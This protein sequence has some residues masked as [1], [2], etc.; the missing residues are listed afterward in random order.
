M[1]EKYSLSWGAIRVVEPTLD[2]V[3]VHAVALADFYNANRA[4]LTNEQDFDATDVVDQFEEM[5]TTGDRPF[6]LYVGQELV[7]DC[8][9]RHIEGDHAE[10]AV[11]VG[12]RTLQARGLGTWFSTM[13]H[14]LAF[15]SLGMRRVYAAVRP[16]NAGSLR[17]F[18][19]LG[20]E[21][22]RTHRYAEA[23]DDVCVS[24]D[25]ET[26]RRVHGAAVA[27]VQIQTRP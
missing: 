9:L 16:E 14:V 23:A 20:Y 13:V 22:D 25:A 27:V 11:L 7:G 4:L 24:I 17:M 19:K 18:E 1:P 15:G 5:W 2:E 3:R 21:R 6:L 26:F 8:D 10:Y 12:P